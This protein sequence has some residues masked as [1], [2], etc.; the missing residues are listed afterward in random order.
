MTTKRTIAATPSAGER[1]AQS[2]ERLRQAL[3][4]AQAPPGNPA[5]NK[6]ANSPMDW[7]NKLGAIPGS[8]AVI[9][10]V[11][12]WWAQHPLRLL[13]HVVTDTAKVLVAPI[14]QRHPLGLV[15]G[16]ALVGGVLTWIRPWRWR[17][18]PGILAGLLPQ[19]LNR[20]AHVPP[21]IW[22]TM[23]AAL[24]QQQAQNQANKTR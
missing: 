17:S 9:D 16:A 11:S 8:S 10:A 5:E 3:R 2:R 13:T 23:L 6:Y 22:L 18:T 19:L 21:P 20:A 12:A 7:L 24:A 15:V 1:L 14:A 4:A